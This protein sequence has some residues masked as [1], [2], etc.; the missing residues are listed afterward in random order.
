MISLERSYHPPH[1]HHRQH[2]TKL[3]RISFWNPPRPFTTIARRFWAKRK[4][5]QKDVLNL[6]LK[7]LII[8]S[9]LMLTYR[10]STRHKSLLRFVSSKRGLLDVN[11]DIRDGWESV[12]ISQTRWL[13]N[14]ASW[15][16]LVVLWLIKHLWSSG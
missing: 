16:L 10:I 2:P 13:I 3:W 6:V 7:L 9:F 5:F 12:D 8:C 14:F 15:Q 1:S 4:P 11:L